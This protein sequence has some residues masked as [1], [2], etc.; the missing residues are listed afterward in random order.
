MPVST[1]KRAGFC[2]S[3]GASRSVNA[4]GNRGPDYAKA[5]RQ[6]SGRTFTLPWSFPLARSRAAGEVSRPTLLARN[7]C[8]TGNLPVQQSAGRSR[9]RERP[10]EKTMFTLQG[11]RIDAGYIADLSL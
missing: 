6:E 3:P 11:L 9:G 8:R 10:E 2:A 1:F 4:L 5:D 7:A